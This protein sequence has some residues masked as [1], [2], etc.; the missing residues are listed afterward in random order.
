MIHWNMK[1][2]NDDKNHLIFWYLLLGKHEAHN[3]IQAGWPGSCCSNWCNDP[4]LVVLNHMVSHFLNIKCFKTVVADPAGFQP[5][6][7]VGGYMTVH[8][9]VVGQVIIPK[10][11]RADLV[12]FLS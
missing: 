12:T 2:L 5:L 7:P 1:Y 3:L 8:V 6:R 9:I 11:I 10:Q 4:N